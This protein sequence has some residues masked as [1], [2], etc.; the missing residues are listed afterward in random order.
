MDLIKVA[1]YILY[2]QVEK[3]HNFESGAS[4]NFLIS[5]ALIF[6]LYSNMDKNW[7]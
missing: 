7:L 1:F 5:R 2:K 6:M 3:M 4:V